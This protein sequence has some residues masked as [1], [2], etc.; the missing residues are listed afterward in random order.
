MACD[1][2]QSLSSDDRDARFEQHVEE[3]YDT[4]HCPNPNCKA[5]LAK[6][7]G[8][9]VVQCGQCQVHTCWACSKLFEGLDGYRRCDA[10]LKETHLQPFLDYVPIV[11]AIEEEDWDD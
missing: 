9:D 8:C 2:Y 11:D 4:K 1:K 3:S 7:E 5:V 6:E 10:H